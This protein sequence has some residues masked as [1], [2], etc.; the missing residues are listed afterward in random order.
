MSREIPSYETI[1]NET[2]YDLDNKPDYIDY[3]TE[4]PMLRCGACGRRNIKSTA[5]KC[6]HCKSFDL[7]EDNPTKS[8]TTIFR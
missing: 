7:I 2:L 5:S 8:I 4:V 6:P 1:K 3:E